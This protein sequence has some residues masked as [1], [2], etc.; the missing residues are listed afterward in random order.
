MPSPPISRADVDALYAQGP[1]AVYAFI[2]QLMTQVTQLETQVAALQA[3]V[4][5]LETQ[6]GKDS[7]NSSKPPSTDASHLAPRRTRSLRRPS[8]RPSGGQPGHPGHTLAWCDTPDTVVSHAPT[9]CAQCT[10]PFAAPPPQRRIAARRQVT[11]VPPLQCH[12]TEHVAE[13]WTCAVCGHETV[14]VF[15]RDARTA[16]Q[17]G[18]RLRAVAVYL[19]SYHLLPLGRTTECLRDLY[20]CA[21]SA[22]AILHAEHTMAT[23]LAPVLA[24]IRLGL[25]RAPV[26]EHDETG[27]YVARQRHWL[28]V[29]STATLT[30]YAVHP[31][32]G[33]LAWDAIGLLADYGG[34][35]VHDGYAAYFR[36]AACT[37]AL[38]NVHLLREL[39]FLAE[40]EGQP[41]ATRLSTLLRQGRRA[42]ARARAAGRPA[43]DPRTV[44]RYRTQV[45]RIV[46]TGKRTNPRVPP[47][48]D[49]T[50]RGTRRRAQSPARKLLDRLTRWEAE[51]LRWLTDLRVPFSTNQAER[52]G[53][54]MKVEQKIS[55]GFRTPQGAATFC[56]LRSYVS[57][58]RKQG[59]TAVTALRLAMLGTPFEPSLA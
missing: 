15:P 33:T 6:Q 30:H 38:C 51:W 58:A 52:D 3:R 55:G 22:G 36:Y 10:Q 12:V 44:A 50:G 41:W 45:R 53:R 34:T 42:V 32:R 56:T 8:G 46:A 35:L 19:T 13:G 20:G 39:T 31:R 9:A 43:L 59:L 47:A 21:M 48:T 57:T 2:V 7:H 40:A 11:E 14:G 28:H 49:R 24:Q 4:H 26:L 27:C 54:M 18:P 23:T 29:A 5:T 37:H 16:V 17:Y 25:T 1:D